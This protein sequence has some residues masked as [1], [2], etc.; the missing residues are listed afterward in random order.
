MAMGIPTLLYNVVKRPVPQAENEYCML[1]FSGDKA[2]AAVKKTVF[3][4]SENMLFY[5]IPLVV[6]I[7]L[8]SLISVRL[9]AGTEKLHRRQTVR[10]ENGVEKEKASDAIRARQ[11]VV[12]MLIGCIIIYFLC[13][14]P[15]AIIVVYNAIHTRPFHKSWYLKVTS[16]ALGYAN[17]AANPIMYS[18]F[19]QNFRRKFKT[20]LRCDRAEKDYKRSITLDSMGGSRGT[21][22][23]T[24]LK[25]TNVSEM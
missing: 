9:F 20:A 18:I 6:Q 7:C 3:K 12:K 8:Y 1:L 24:S 17:S 21:T 16:F 10:S 13:Y 14:L 5:F 22:R 19:S 23:F 11:G 2:S 4:V 15:Q 25:Q